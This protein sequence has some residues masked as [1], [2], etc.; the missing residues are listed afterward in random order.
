[1]LNDAHGSLQSLRPQARSLSAA[2]PLRIR[3]NRRA[4]VCI[5]VNAGKNR[6]TCVS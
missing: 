6:C 5:R 3:I 4:T 2:F 1:V